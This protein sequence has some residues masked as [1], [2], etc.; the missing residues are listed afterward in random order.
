[1]LSFKARGAPGRPVSHRG[2][3][4]WRGGFFLSACERF[5]KI[6]MMKVRLTSV[7]TA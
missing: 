4:G 3:R 5:L 2:G 1:V 6:E 7:S